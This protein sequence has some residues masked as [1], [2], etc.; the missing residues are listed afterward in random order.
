MSKDDPYVS[1]VRNAGD[2]RKPKPGRT[3]EET[4]FAQHLRR[5]VSRTE[6]KLWLHLRGEQM[7]APFRRQHVVDHA[8]PDYCCV[9]LRLIVEVDGPQHDLNRDARRDAR[10]NRH[11]YDVIRF[12][13]QQIDQDL[14]G[15][16]DT[17]YDAVQLRLM[18]R[19]HRAKSG[20]AKS[21]S[22]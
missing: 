1:R 22:D 17:I 19:E 4:K 21:G 8:F 10:M 2:R 11:G 20:S 15:V 16:V 7:G 6:D 18:E 9:P 5:T 12:G 13:V 14:Q 3:R